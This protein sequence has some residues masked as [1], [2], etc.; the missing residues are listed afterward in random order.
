[1]DIILPI[2]VIFAFYRLQSQKLTFRFNSKYFFPA[3]L[4]AY[5]LLIIS[6]CISD[7]VPQLPLKFPF[8]IISVL[9]P[10]FLYKDCYS[11]RIFWVFLSY[12][13][14]TVSEVV[15][16]F[17]LS[18]CFKLD[19]SFIVSASPYQLI[20]SFVAYLLLLIM[21]EAIIHSTKNKPRIIDNFKIELISMISVD[22]LFM[23]VFAGLFYYKNIFITVNDAIILMFISF[24]LISIIT[25]FTLYKVAKKSNE[26][27]QT[28][29]KLQQIEME[30][31]LTEN[32]TDVVENL[33]N[34]RHD[35]NNH[36]GILQGLLSLHEY[37]EATQY[38]N[39]LLEDLNVANNFVFVDNKL[40]SVLI[41]SKIS[42]AI[43]LNIHV[44]TEIHVNT[45]PLDDRDLCALVG[46]ILENAIEAASFSNEAHINFSMKK[47]NSQLTIQCENS[48]SVEPVFHNGELITTKE[49]KKYHGIG[50]KIIKS[51]VETYNGQVNFF[52][53]ELFHVDISIPY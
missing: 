5:I 34:L 11:K 2:I 12:L 37:D 50:T 40:L 51:T 39:S 20:G 36:L 17:V 27:M 31:K 41:N 35:M 43:A 14:Y 47:E 22:I 1:M 7:W 3:Y 26:M 49:D 48:F 53:D 46:N 33:R 6:G 42:K 32:M 8:L 38:L 9:Y 18:F 16:A 52:V 28:N 24:A 13:L 15:I 44:E 23:L 10:F 25:F 21:V 29:L 4:I 45:F 30:N 19:S